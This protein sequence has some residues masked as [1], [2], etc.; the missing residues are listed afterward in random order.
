MRKHSIVAGLFV[1]AG[2]AGCG[3]S[4]QHPTAQVAKSDC[5]GLTDLDAQ[6]AGLYAPGNVQKVEPVYRQNYPHRDVKP[7]EISGASLYVAAPPGVSEAYLERALSCHA[8]GRATANHDGDPLRVP[9]V[10]DVDV[11]AAGPSMRIA[12]TGFDREAADAILERARA[13]EHHG[14]RVRVEQIAHGPAS[15]PAL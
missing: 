12:I 11:T 3:A 8:S 5:R 1:A 6:I 2:I 7:R 9:G 15:E 13:L 10:D 14:G 4:A